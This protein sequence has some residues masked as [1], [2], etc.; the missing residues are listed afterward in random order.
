MATQII[1]PIQVFLDTQRLIQV[2]SP[3]TF[4]P[5]RDFFAGDNYG[6]RRHKARLQEQ[7]RAA[8]EGLRTDSNPAGFVMVQ[9][10]EEGLGKSY[11][12]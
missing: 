4:G 6:F 9:M 12:P 5:S 10:R 2:Q 8:S 7:L 3:G 1:R 11:R